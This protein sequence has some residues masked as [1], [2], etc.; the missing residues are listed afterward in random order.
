MGRKDRQVEMK[1]KKSFVLCWILLFHILIGAVVAA[2]SSLSSG[3]LIAYLM[4][5]GMYV[6]DSAILAKKCIGSSVKDMQIF[7]PR[8]ISIISVLFIVGGV[9]VL[10]FLLNDQEIKQYDS[11]VYWIKVINSGKCLNSSPLEFLKQVRSSLAG[12]YTNLA[13][14]P[15]IP[16]CMAMEMSFCGLG[17]SVYVM[18]YVPMC[19]LAAL[20]VAR[21]VNC[22]SPEKTRVAFIVTVASAVLMVPM[23]YPL[24]CGYVDVSGLVIALMLMHLSRNKKLWNIGIAD[25][26]CYV[27]LSTLL[28]FTRRWYSFFV[29]SFYFS[30]GVEWVLDQIRSGRIDWKSFAQLISR[31]VGI[32]AMCVALMLLLSTDSLKM[33]FR[34]DYTF[35]Y[36]AY[37]ERPWYM[38]LRQIAQVA[39]GWYSFI[40]VLGLGNMLLK[41]E[42]RQNCLEMCVI[43][44][45][46]F[47]LFEQIQSMGIHHRYLVLVFIL[48]WYSI[49][50]TELIT[51]RGAWLGAALLFL[52]AGI[53][54]ANFAQS[55]LVENHEMIESPLFSNIHYQPKDPE[56]YWVVHEISDDLM[57]LTEGKR[58]FYVCSDSE[59]MTSELISR[60]RLPEVVD[61]FPNM[62]E[63]SIIDMRDGFPSQ[64]FFADYIVTAKS[65]QENIVNKQQ[66]I[67]M[68]IQ[69]LET[70]P[71]FAQ[72]YEVVQTYQ[73]DNQTVK[74][75]EK[76]K[77]IS[78]EH[79]LILSR[80]LQKAYPAYEYIYKPDYYISLMQFHHTQSI[81]YDPWEIL[82]D[83]AKGSALT[84]EWQL[85][86]RFD[87]IQ[88]S[89]GGWMGGLSMKVYHDERCIEERVLPDNGIHQYEFEIN[90]VNNL[91]IEF[92]TEGD[93]IEGVLH[94]TDGVLIE[95]DMNN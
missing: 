74:I 60:S 65:H 18:Y 29:V 50:M 49:G 59:L 8:M 33:F 61:A 17:V 43:V 84:V 7:T 41:P 67:Q 73:D 15:L 32:A 94:F 42:T 62:V 25:G 20:Y 91:R 68:P 89:F 71:E 12:E 44:G 10:S 77:N 23:V 86:G 1:Q 93:Q 81:C 76:K 14:L 9:F 82:V 92:G 34:N 87:L 40:A 64:M 90:G 36:S 27:L 31:L 45:I 47:A 54:T 53:L 83:K 57:E 37:K 56:A 79:V 3:Y 52:S 88:C 26:A 38:D 95:T 28:V 22:Y 24:L 39:G 66:I 72:V 6:T 58:T 2:T 16:I 11:T 30:I 13:A 63:N 85:D 35:A 70:C 78:A 69:I 75:Y 5:F 48:I 55:F 46:A 21:I 4:L 51:I 80:K 19:L